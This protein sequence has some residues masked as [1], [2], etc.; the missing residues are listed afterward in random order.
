MLALNTGFFA[1]Y[2]T[3]DR[4]AF[5]LPTFIMFAFAGSLAVDDLWGRL[6]GGGARRAPRAALVA[7][8]LISLLVPP[9]FYSRLADW[10]SEPGF[11]SRRYGHEYHGNV[12]NFA[13]YLANP[14]KRHWNDAE[15]YA[16]LLFETL[17]KN[18]VYIDDSSR[19]Y[20]PV[21]YF[22]RY[23]HKRLD[24]KVHLVNAWGFSNWG[25]GRKE[26][27]GKIREAWRKDRNLYLP[28]LRQPFRRLL[29]PIELGSAKPTFEI[30]TLDERRYIYRLVTAREL[31]TP[32]RDRSHDVRVR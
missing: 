30:I 23:F 13:E 4:Y 32:N 25:L 28:S 14:N 17:P 12:V 5:L 18:A 20:Y 7:L 16:N 26:F 11:L 15:E 22:R 6:E 3:W 24:L 29:R 19:T 31:A 10:G 9:W 2:D 8:M 1:L 27:T 21:F